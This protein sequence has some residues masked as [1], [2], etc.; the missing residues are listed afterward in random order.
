MRI[1]ATTALLA[2]TVAAISPSPAAD[3]AVHAA[4]AKALAKVCKEKVDAAARPEW[5]DPTPAILDFKAQLDTLGVKLIVLPVPPKASVYP[6]KLTDVV[7]FDAKEG[8]PRTDAHTAAYLALLRTRG[9]DV[10]DVAPL[11][12]KARADD[13]RK[14][15]LYCRTDTH[16]SPRSCELIAAAIADKLGADGLTKDVTPRRVAAE[17]RKVT[18]T[19]DLTRMRNGNEGETLPARFVGEKGAD[20]LT[21]LADD[22]SSPFVL[23]GDSHAL[24][25]HAGG[26]MH[27]RGAGLADQLAFELKTPIDVVAVRGSGATPARIN[28][29]RTARRDA[30]YLKGK[31]AVVWCFAAREFTESAG[32]R[33]V[34]VVKRP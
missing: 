1:R 8:S 19:G 22:P 17:R 2:V 21:P 26:D 18:F 9:V 23:L 14:G 3:T 5:A 32:W 29:M 15:S 34:P 7:A 12:L 13:A 28:L 20:G 24:V 25:F 27:A 30:N 6:D 16:Y 31:K 11:L 4:A 10:M 33:K